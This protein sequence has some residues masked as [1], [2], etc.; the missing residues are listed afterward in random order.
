MEKTEAV[1]FLNIKDNKYIQRMVKHDTLFLICP[2]VKIND[3]GKKQDR[4]IVVTDKHF[5]NVKSGC[6]F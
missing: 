6:T 2:V 1:D 4:I 5:F 3:E